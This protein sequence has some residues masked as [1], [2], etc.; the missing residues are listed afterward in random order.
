LK[1]T[2]RYLTDYVDGLSA[3]NFMPCELAFLAGIEPGFDFFAL[4]HKAERYGFLAVRQVPENAD[5]IEVH[6]VVV[7]FG[8]QKMKKLRDQF[9]QF[10]RWC[11]DQGVKEVC[12]FK[13]PEQSQ[14]PLWHR[15]V[16]MLGFDSPQTMYLT[17]KP[18]EA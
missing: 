3:L 11:R 7:K 17:Q 14:D 8:P 10:Q 2:T 9:R 5:G 13:L 12:T 15:F 18:V 16:G 6:L 4:F 1:T